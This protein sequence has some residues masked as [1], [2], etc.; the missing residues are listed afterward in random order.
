MDKTIVRRTFWF[1]PAMRHS[2]VNLTVYSQTVPVYGRNLFKKK[3]YKQRYVEKQPEISQFKNCTAMMNDKRFPL[4]LYFSWFVVACDESFNATFI[5]ESPT[6]VQGSI[7]H[8]ITSNSSCDKD[9]FQ[10]HDNCF[11]IFASSSPVIITKLVAN[12]VHTTV[13]C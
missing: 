3:R 12:A 7:N 13:L 6:G 8:Y 11:K 2:T 4:T 1:D 9:W 10:L 5:C